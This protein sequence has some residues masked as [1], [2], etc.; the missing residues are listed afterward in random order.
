MDLEGELLG[1]L[2]IGFRADTAVERGDAVADERA[3]IADVERLVEAALH[4]EAELRVAGVR[5]LARR[6]A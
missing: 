3:Q 1:A 2:A 5:G 6:G 4:L